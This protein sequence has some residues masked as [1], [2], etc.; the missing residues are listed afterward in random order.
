MKITK[1]SLN[2]NSTDSESSEG[3]NGILLKIAGVILF[4]LLL[5]NLFAYLD[6]ITKL[7]KCPYPAEYGEGVVYNLCFRMISGEK[8][9]HPIDEIPY[10]HTPY[11]PLYFFVSSTLM[12]ITSVSPVICR[13][14]SIASAFGIAIIVFL[15][16]FFRTGSY[17]AALLFSLFLFSSPFFFEWT[18]L[19]RVDTIGIFF[20]LIGLM[21]ASSYKEK[22]YYIYISIPFFLI[23]IMTKQSLFAAPFAVIIYLIFVNWKK[24]VKFIGIFSGSLVLLYYI[25]QN[26]TEGNFYF[27]ALRCNL[28]SFDLSAALMALGITGT[29]YYGLVSLSVLSFFMALKDKEITPAHIYLVTTFFTAL[30]IGKEGGANNHL[31]E[32]VI[33]CSINAGF[34]AVYFQRRLNLNFRKA[35]MLFPVILMLAQVISLYFID[36]SITNKMSRKSLGSKKKPVAW[37]PYNQSKL[38]EYDRLDV[39]QYIQVSKYIKNVAG[40]VLCENVGLLTVNGKK[41][42]YQPFQFKHLAQMGKFDESKILT[43]IKNG[44]FDLV[45]MTRN[46]VEDGYSWLYSDRIIDAIWQNYAPIKTIGEYDIY[47]YIRGLM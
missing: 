29:A 1:Q 25:M 26:I 19:I 8:I 36:T 5:F 24:A 17:F 11:T 9:Y 39:K 22:D 30:S 41:V 47:A 33:A 6:Y 23:A 45:I 32:F 2:S 35:G 20:T 15:L 43:M 12:K 4:F 16:V 42:F 10:V 7:I 3:C 46:S 18:P 28:I 40:P 21:L 27:H 34:A 31:I 13:S 37:T 14:V 44:E 38:P